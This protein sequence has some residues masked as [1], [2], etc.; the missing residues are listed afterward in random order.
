MSDVCERTDTD[1]Q[2]AVVVAQPQV[3]T[4]EVGKAVTSSHEEAGFAPIASA[5]PR[6]A[7]ADG[8]AE[9][10]LGA[11]SLGAEGPGSV[12]VATSIVP[13]ASTPTG[14][15][16]EGGAGVDMINDLPDFGEGVNDAAVL[17]MLRALLA[18]C[19]KAQV[20]VVEELKRVRPV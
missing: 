20:L 14:A 10:E 9:I 15:A 3:S 13:V 4:P 18:L 6:G 16:A 2:K 5:V 11:N 19:I 7:S 8:E 17:E 1:K 12:A